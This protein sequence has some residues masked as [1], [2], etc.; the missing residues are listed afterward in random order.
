[1][2]GAAVQPCFGFTVSSLDEAAQV[3]AVQQAMNE[4]RGLRA[5]QINVANLHA[6]AHDPWLAQ[7]FRRAELLSAEGRGLYFASR[8]VAPRISSPLTGI[9]LMYGLLEGAAARGDRFFFLGA[10]PEVLAEAVARVR[11]RYGEIV[12]GAHHGYYQTEVEQHAIAEAVRASGANLVLVGMST[13]KKEAWIDRWTGD[14]GVPH[15]GVGGSFDVLAGQVRLAPRWVRSAGLE[16]AF[17]LVQE[18]R[19]LAL[20]YLRTNLWF[21]ALVARRLVTR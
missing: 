15:L 19:R 17:R 18:P 3:R 10:Q 4:R 6:A 9:G 2:T 20:R 7:A 12:A 1:M 8:L 14:L 11:A 21:A 13:P 16:W 5:L